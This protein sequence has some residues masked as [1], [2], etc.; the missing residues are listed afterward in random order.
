MASVAC[1]LE[2]QKE[3]Q[4]QKE[5]RKYFSSIFS[6]FNKKGEKG[7]VDTVFVVETFST[8]CVVWTP[9]EEGEQCLWCL[10]NSSPILW[11]EFLV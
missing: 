7:L 8:S 3:A 4:N 6:V 9:G 10:V 11:S 2:K 1:W 5:G